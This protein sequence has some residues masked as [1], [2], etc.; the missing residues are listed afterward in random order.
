MR[1]FKMI[2]LAPLF[3]AYVCLSA[4]NSFA[5]EK[6]KQADKRAESNST[7]FLSFDLKKDIEQFKLYN[8]GDCPYIISGFPIIPTFKPIFVV[9]EEGEIVVDE[10]L[11]CNKKVIDSYSGPILTPYKSKNKAKD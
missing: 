2:V 10:D 3:F 1:N 7:S 11:H 5:Q 6:E 8:Q 4:D 9:N